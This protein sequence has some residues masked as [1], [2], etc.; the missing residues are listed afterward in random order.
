MSLLAWSVLLPYHASCFGE[1]LVRVH[2]VNV[3]FNEGRD[4]GLVYGSLVQFS[5]TNSIV[6]NISIVS[7]L[8]QKSF[9]FDCVEC[10]FSCYRG[11]FDGLSN[12]FGH[13]SGGNIRL[14]A[15]KFQ[16][17]VRPVTADEYDCHGSERGRVDII[18]TSLTLTSCWF[19]NI[20][21]PRG[22]G[23]A[24][25]VWN[26]PYFLLTF[27]QFINCSA[28][29]G[30]GSAVYANTATVSCCVCL[31]KEMTTP[32][33]VLHLQRGARPPGVFGPLSLTSLTFSSIKVKTT[34]DG[35][36][37]GGGSGLVIRYI[38]ELKL[39][40]CRF[41]NCGFDYT[42]SNKTAGALMFE[43]PQKDHLIDSILLKGCTFTRSHAGT[44]CIRIM[45]VVK[46]F[47]MD[48][49]QVDGCSSGYSY[50][51]Y[52]IRVGAELMSFT[53]LR[54]MNMPE[55]YGKLR[56]DSV[57]NETISFKNCTFEKWMT[58]SLVVTSLDVSMNVCF[59]T[60]RSVTVPDSNLFRQDSDT[61][62]LTIT[63]CTFED[64]EA[65]GALIS[66]WH[67][68]CS[69]QSNCVFES[70][71]IQNEPVLFFEN[72]P[73]LEVNLDSVIL[74][75]CHGL[76]G[77]L[78]VTANVILSLFNVSCIDIPAISGS[79]VMF[80]I[81][82]SIVE[83]LERCAFINCQSDKAPIVAISWL[84][85]NVLADFIFEG[86]WSYNKPILVI[87]NRDVTLK[88]C[89]FKQMPSFP[90][91]LMTIDTKGS[92]S[93]K[94]ENVTFS[95][96]GCTYSGEI[97]PLISLGYDNPVGLSAHSLLIS[98]CSFTSLISDVIE[99]QCVVSHSVFSGNRIGSHLFNV[100]GC[101]LSLQDCNFSECDC[102][103]LVV[104]NGPEIRLTKCDFDRC[105]SLSPLIEANTLSILLDTCCF[106]GST[107]IYIR[108]IQE[109]A[110]WKLEMP[111]CF[112]QSQ[113]EDVDFAGPDP[114][115]NLTSQFHIFNCDTC[116][117]PLPVMP[118]D[119]SSLTETDVFTD[120]E[121]FTSDEGS[122]L[123]DTEYALIGGF[124]VLGVVLILILVCILARRRKQRP[125][126]IEIYEGDRLAVGS[127]LI[128]GYDGGGIGGV[129]QS[130]PIDSNP[131]Q[132]QYEE[133]I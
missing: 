52:S 82:S 42:S 103:S 104:S 12:H 60:F 129:M 120:T 64:I 109:K 97:Q 29:N 75:N 67:G 22:P 79:R 107:C 90:G 102:S 1:S 61:A 32:Y 93:I 123:G 122:S 119:M 36:V 86:C 69:I 49:C 74:R 38:S 126:F 106:H 85:E 55:G 88:S 76:T 48:Y 27:C 63:G 118:T 71:K 114:F 39:T 30:W 133:V 44:G 31:F 9:L 128:R 96:V 132:N 73:R 24:V 111:L 105:S 53:H 101:D 28:E 80:D 43:R 125:T 46:K 17:S 34:W 18:N 130:M 115:L 112:D 78:R 57:N 40:D 94:L 13:F 121:I 47:E 21:G 3:S 11:E 8:L 117:S 113:S 72:S 108:S 70:V 54:L 58:L 7:R 59:C 25:C 89:V 92:V 124:S 127:P 81:S 91:P 4:P 66:G 10:S 83:R 56:L 99:N 33:S 100:S 20:Q 16:R 50:N 26:A 110:Q 68:C 65:E 6:S 15:L 98:K 131:F 2:L 84:P 51:P 37:E 41:T 35:T 45:N 77:I 23:G 19:Y 62:T 14:E 5:H 87:R 116:D 95:D